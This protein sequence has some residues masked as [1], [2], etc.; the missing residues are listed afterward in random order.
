MFVFST[1]AERECVDLVDGERLTWG[2]I[3]V[4]EL[5]RERVARSAEAM[6]EARSIRGEGEPGWEWL[7]VLPCD[8]DIPMG[9][10]GVPYVAW[11][12]FVSIVSGAISYSVVCV[13]LLSDTGTKYWSISI[14]SELVSSLD[15]GCCRT[16]LG[17][18]GRGASGGMG[19]WRIGGER[20]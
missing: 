8:G 2:K 7:Y 17:N 19:K 18:G 5:L 9:E 11:A 12:T 4:E 1:A 6:D 10:D 15:D 14:G 3:D 16:H 13:D 20:T